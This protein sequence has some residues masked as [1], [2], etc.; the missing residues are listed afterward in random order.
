[1]NLKNLDADEL[2]QMVQLT[3]K[4]TELE[5]ALCNRL[6]ASQK[7]LKRLRDIVDEEL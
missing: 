3:D 2:I 6:I 4:P 1:M 7:V 5:K